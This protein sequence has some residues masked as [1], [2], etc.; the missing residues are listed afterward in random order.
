LLQI[1]PGSASQGKGAGEPIGTGT[2]GHLELEP[3]VIVNRECQSAALTLI[4][5]IAGAGSLAALALPAQAGDKPAPAAVY[6]EEQSTRGEAVSTK[7]CAVCH[8]EQL[9]GDLAPPLQGDDFRKGW[10][11]KTAGALFDK[12]ITTMPANEPGT[13]TEQQSA[14]LVAYILKLNNFPAGQEP[15]PKD[16][17]ALNA[18]PL[19]P[20]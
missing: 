12:I 9:K 1:V 6:T 20:K 15:L 11:D 16:V 10:S 19:A 8:G 2:I 13:I 4:V 5:L 7:S 17:A 18:I 3:E 14:D